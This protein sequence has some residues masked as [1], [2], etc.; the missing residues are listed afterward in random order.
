MKI[1]ILATAT[2]PDK[3]TIEGEKITA[4]HGNQSEEFDLSVIEHG[5]RF[6][7]VEPETLSLSGFQVIRK[8][9]RDDQGELHVT[10]TEKSPLNGHWRESDWMDAEDYYEGNAGRHIKQQ[11]KNGPEELSKPYVKVDGQWVEVDNG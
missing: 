3:Y 2:S 1:K 7:A 4:H 10:L 6:Q 11:T 9:Y 5:G 8:A